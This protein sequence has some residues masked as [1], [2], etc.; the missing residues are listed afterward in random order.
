[1]PKNPSVD[2][3]LVTSPSDAGEKR[4]LPRNLHWIII[5]LL[6]T[7]LGIVIIGSAVD[8]EAADAEKTEQQDSETRKAALGIAQPVDARGIEG[9]KTEQ[10]STVPSISQPSQLGAAG[11]PGLAK[12]PPVPDDGVKVQPRTSAELRQEA[13]KLEEI[14]RKR[15]QREETISSSGLLAIKGKGIRAGETTERSAQAPALGS[16]ED[17]ARLRNEAI[18][19]TRQRAVSNHPSQ[20]MLLR[21][22]MN[23]QGMLPGPYGVDPYN[24]AAQSGA[25]TNS[26]WLQEQEMKAAGASQVLRAEQPSSHNVLMQGSI[27]PVALVTALNSDMPGQIVA[28]TT[29]DVYDSIKGTSLIIP[30][31][32][33]LYGQYN[34]EVRIGQERAV[35]AFSRLIRPDG[36]YINLLGMPAADAMGQS[37]L[38]GDVNNHFLKM[39]GAS[40]ATAGL[41]ALFDSSTNKTVVVS[42]G[43]TGSVSGAAGDVLVDVAKRINQRNSNIPPTITVPSGTRFVITITKD[44]DI[45]PYRGR[46]PGQ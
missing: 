29:S 9:I 24:P 7:A 17:L 15:Q 14:E 44:I 19:A 42:G 39:F 40:F 25:A 41:A 6:I 36:S 26:R 3:C 33:K 32:S 31:G 10:E 11:T 35:A 45:P 12:L 13:D 28:Q 16:A 46:L 37:G 38:E 43:S 22:G 34:A 23:Q 27:I 18:A 21:A 8:K 4:G 20:E 5:G 1:M 2:E 30:R